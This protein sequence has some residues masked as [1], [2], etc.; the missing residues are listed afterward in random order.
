MSGPDLQGESIHFASAEERSCCLFINPPPPPAR[1]PQ[2]ERKNYGKTC[3]NNHESE[4]FIVCEVRKVR[5]TQGCRERERNE[6]YRQQLL[7]QTFRFILPF[8]LVSFQIQITKI[9][10]EASKSKAFLSIRHISRASFSFAR[11]TR[12]LYNLLH[13]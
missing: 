2:K 11:F 12:F 10:D 3:Q 7:H 9:C 6:N 8:C 13:Y 5:E 4:C 1:R